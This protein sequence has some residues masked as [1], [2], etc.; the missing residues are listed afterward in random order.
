MH[1][2]CFAPTDVYGMGT[3]VKPQVCIGMHVDMRADM[4]IEMRVD[5]RLDMRVDMRHGCHQIRTG[6]YE[7]ERAACMC[8]CV[9]TSH[10]HMCMCLDQPQACVHVSGPATCM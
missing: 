7:R 2:A 6:L 10:R 9:W 3:V 5:M 1:K 4:R 8:A